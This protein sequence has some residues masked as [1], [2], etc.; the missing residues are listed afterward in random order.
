MGFYT[1]IRSRLFF[2][3]LNTGFDCDVKSRIHNTDSNFFLKFGENLV[4]CLC[5][6]RL[7]REEDS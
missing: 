6:F 5:D 1:D 2:G 7:S 4:C 3:F